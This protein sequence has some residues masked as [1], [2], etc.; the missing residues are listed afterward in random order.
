MVI[1]NIENIKP[2]KNFLS[3][4]SNGR[5][6][7]IYKIENINTQNDIFYPECLFFKEDEIINPSSEKIMSL[8]LAEDI[9]DFKFESSKIKNEVNVPLFFFVYNTDNYYHFIY[10]SLPYL[11]TYLELRKTL[12]ELK[13][14]MNYPNFQKKE[15]YKFVTEFLDLLNINKNDIIIIEKYTKYSQVYISDSFTHGNDSN[16]PPREEIYDFYTKIV[17]IALS[18]S[19]IDKSTLP[20]KIYVSRRTWLHGDTSNIGTNYTNRRKLECENELVIFLENQGIKEIFTEKLTTIEKIILFS[21][22]DLVIGSIGG[23]LCNL[24]FSKKDCK[25]IT[26]CSPTF[27]EI[28][29]RFRFCFSK[30]NTLYYDNTFHVEKDFWKKWM[31]VKSNNIIGEIEEVLENELIILYTQ[32]KVAGWNSEMNYDI[33]KLKKEECFALDKGLNSSWNFDIEDFKKIIK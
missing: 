6:I 26:L 30:I 28:N 13:L 4:D 18:K 27:L 10:D 17:N 5:I 31:R 29:S 22:A 12:P 7:N 32:N 16:L 15:F 33:I 23:G 24:L 1:L 14:L 11:I 20:K 21:N 8:S 25:L 3:K 2:Y 9:M 19:N